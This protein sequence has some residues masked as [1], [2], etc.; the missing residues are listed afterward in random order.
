V[1][2][3][4]SNDNTDNSFVDVNHGSKQSFD[5][6][7]RGRMFLVVLNLRLRFSAECAF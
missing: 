4:G 2:F 1:L 5:F 7:I 6:G 3:Q